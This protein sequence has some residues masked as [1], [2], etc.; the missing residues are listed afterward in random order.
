MA[1][2]DADLSGGNWRWNKILSCPMPITSTTPAGKSKLSALQQEIDSKQQD[3]DRLKMRLAA[4]Q[5]LHHVPSL[6][7]NLPVNL[8][9]RSRRSPK[10]H[11]L[12]FPHRASILGVAAVFLIPQRHH[13][14]LWCFFLTP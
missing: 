2:K 10:H 4:M 13:Y 9:L 6:P 11:T 1:E 5:E 8:L 14:L 12:E 3:V 7:L